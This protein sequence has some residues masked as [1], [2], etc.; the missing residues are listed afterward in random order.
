MDGDRAGRGTL[1][2]RRG[3]PRAAAQGRG[4]AR[5]ARARLAGR[6]RYRR[7]GSRR[8]RR[9]GR[10]RG[11]VRRRGRSA[12]VRSNPA[13]ALAALA[14]FVEHRLA[15]VR[16]VRGRDHARR[17][18]DGSLVALRAAEPRSVGSDGGRP[19]GRGQRTTTGARRLAAVEGFIRQVIG[20]R[21]YVWHLYWY[22]GEDY[23]TNNE[24]NQRRLDPGLV[25][26]SGPG[27]HGGGLRRSA[28]ASVRDAGW[29][30]HIPRLMV[31]GNYALQ[32]GWRPQQ[33]TD[34]F[35]RSLRGRLRLGDGAERRRDEPAR[36]DGG[37]LA[38]KP[39]VSGG[40]YVDK[41]SDHCHEARRFDPKKRVGGGRV[42]VHRRRPR[43]FLHEH[44]ERFE[45][46]PRMT[47]A[48]SGLD[49]LQRPRRAARRRSTSGLG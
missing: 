10:R 1:E 30:H 22:L 31:L 24:L 41:M 5:P 43:R 28:L 38:T 13:E 39:Y 35:H 47:Q 19:G 45:A 18:L 12:A 16:P 42:P 29:A 25:R 14:D 23:R 34:W 15:I 37:V 32:H 40:A 46:N 6:G 11:G 3:E 4:N 36:G 27:R 21:D 48:L 33:L 17:P 20:W 49:R 26:R 9:D 8:P 44:R 2:L 7:A